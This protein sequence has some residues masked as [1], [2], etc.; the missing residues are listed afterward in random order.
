MKFK[1]DTKEGELFHSYCVVGDCRESKDIVC[2]F[3]EKDLKFKTKGNPD[4]L[5]SQYDVL[6]VD[7]SREIKNAQLQ[8]PTAGDKKIFLISANFI[9]EQAQNSMLKMFEEPIPHTHF[10][11]I[12]PSS[13][14]FIPTL[15]SRMVFWDL[16]SGEQTSLSDLDPIVFLK[17]GY[18]KRFELIKK[19]SEKIS[20]DEKS[21]IEVID[22]FQ[23]LEREI[24][25]NF[26][27][28]ES[29]AWL[30]EIERVRLYAM[31]QSPSLKMLMEHISLLLPMLN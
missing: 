31:E 7:E 22:F 13:K 5:F 27:I 10:F 29:Y 15:K 4:F 2:A 21:K 18:G 25:K 23:S 11:L 17:N 30:E 6:G 24:R 20:D 12:S 26:K 1:P 19:L 28:K 14:N 16:R 9:T 8:R 3:L